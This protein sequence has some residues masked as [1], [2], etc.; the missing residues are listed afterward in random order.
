[1]SDSNTKKMTELA[2]AAL[3]LDEELRR[4]EALT[5][6]ALRVP[7]DS[8]KNLERAAAACQQRV[9][10]L[11][12]AFMAALNVAREANQRAAEQLTQKGAEVQARSAVYSSLYEKYAA[13]GQEASEI[14]ST[15]ARVGAEKAQKGREAL[16]DL[17]EIEARMTAVVDRAQELGREAKEADF[18]D[19]VSQLDSLRQQTQ[20]ARNKVKLL[21]QQLGGP[22]AQVPN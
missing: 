8:K 10:E 4:F 5:A 20:S 15:V 6:S 16:G 18:E 14:S 1:M 13:L 12:H 9:S 3:A 19:L 7:L 22:T 17:A 2:R 11:V 21:R